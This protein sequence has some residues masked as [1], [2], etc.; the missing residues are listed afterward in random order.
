M[1]YLLCV[2]CGLTILKVAIFDLT[3][4][5]LAETRRSTPRTGVYVDSAA[6]WLGVATCIQ[7][8]LEVSRI[9]AADILAVGLSGHGNGLYALDE[10]GA[11]VIAVSSMFDLNEPQVDAF[12]R[13]DGY[14]AFFKL[15]H[16]M[17]W[18]GQPM[19]I[20]KWLRHEQPE[21]Y[22]RIRHVL[23]CK[24]FLRYKLTGSFATD[25]S[26]FT[27][28]ALAMGQQGMILCRMLDIPEMASCLPM[29]LACDQISGF[30][31]AQAARE[32]GLRQG[33]PVA[34][35]GIDLFCCMQGTGIVDSGMCSIT[36][37]TWGVAAA[38]AEAIDHP[39]ALTQQCVF[40]RNFKPAAVVSA[41]TSCVNLDWFLHRIRP[42]LSY[43][44]ASQIVA[45]FA[46]SKVQAIYLPYIYRDMS[47][48][49]IRAGFRDVSSTDGWQELLG[50]VYEG[51]CFA[52]KL[53][54]D[55]LRRAGVR[56]D[57]ARLSGGM[58]N[59]P[60]W[61]QMMSSIL[62]IEIGIPVEKQA[63][64]L[65]TAMMA[66]VCVDAYP[67]LAEAGRQMGG[68]ERIYIPRVDAAY[69]EKYDRF[70]RMAGEET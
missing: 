18:G 28:S 26:D 38:Y 58:T 53:Q 14:D 40:Q 57:S 17:A 25:D 32:T 5:K 48:P 35:G 66:A 43:D 12:R 49:E 61:C 41:P 16:Q 1:Q 11:T 10:Q 20:L 24:D 55:R 60:I 13:S 46:P 31:S 65:G 64:L 6:L 47:R 30:I 69:E 33:T 22:K 56:I 19:Q 44:D 4:A 37:G 42:G 51:V 62:Q 52:H 39:Q 23:M 70:L 34:A 67:T 45:Q 63:G 59:S 68:V 7:K 27:A 36:A 50:A 29:P 15:T 54:I 8:A 2:D 21:S 9:S 3:G